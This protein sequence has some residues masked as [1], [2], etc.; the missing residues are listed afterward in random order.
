M[1]GGQRRF[2]LHCSLVT[3]LISTLAANLAG[4]KMVKMNLLRPKIEMTVKV[5]VINQMTET[6]L[7]R[8][9]NNS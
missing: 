8:R 4:Q 3:C 9:K 2:C 5:P 1:E 6:P 7:G